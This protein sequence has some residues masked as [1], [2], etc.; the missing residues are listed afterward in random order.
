MCRKTKFA[1]WLITSILIYVAVVSV[2]HSIYAESRIH[3]LEQ[4]LDYL[5]SELVKIHEEQEK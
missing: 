4:N 5:T 1:R 2:G 3:A